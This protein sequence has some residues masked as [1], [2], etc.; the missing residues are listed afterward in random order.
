MP[1]FK[2]YDELRQ[3]LADEIMVAIEDTMAET[4]ISSV[5]KRL[6]PE[7]LEFMRLIESNSPVS[8]YIANKASDKQVLTRLK[9][10][11]LIIPLKSSQDSTN[12]V[13]D[14]TA[15]GI[16]LLKSYQTD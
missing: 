8:F 7:D 4:E 2:Q 12:Y 16:D 15:F 6:L 13:Y 10:R 11:G 9:A 3:S 14:L 5:K 1:V